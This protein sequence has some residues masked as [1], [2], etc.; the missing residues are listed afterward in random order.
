MQC[1]LQAVP[2]VARGDRAYREIGHRYFP[3]YRRF[4]F[5]FFHRLYVFSYS[6]AMHQHT[7]KKRCPSC[8]LEH[9]T[10]RSAMSLK[11]EGSGWGVFMGVGTVTEDERALS[12]PRHQWH[13][14]DGHSWRFSWWLNWALCQNKHDFSIWHLPVTKAI[15]SS[16]TF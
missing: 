2:W 14:L 8:L 13:S 5:L 4:G 1:V 10:F 6:L 3:D 16:W 9:F 12:I 15:T 11:R 7:V